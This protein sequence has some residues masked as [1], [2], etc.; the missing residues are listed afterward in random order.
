ML[1][2]LRPAR[3]VPAHGMLCSECLK[4]CAVYALIGEA[5]PGEEGPFG[6]RVCIGCLRRTLWAFE[7]HLKRPD[8]VTFEGPDGPVTLSAEE[9]ERIEEQ[10]LLRCTPPDETRGAS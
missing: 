10:I 3:I 1:G 2:A 5:L 6:V 7:D 9:M 4:L 8:D